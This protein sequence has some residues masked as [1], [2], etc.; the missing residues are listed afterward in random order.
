MSSNLILNS[1]YIYIV[2]SFYSLF[3][4]I[5]S[6]LTLQKYFPSLYSP[7][8]WVTMSLLLMF[9]VL[10]L[11][12]HFPES[13][14]HF[15][16]FVA[17]KCFHSQFSCSEF[18]LEEQFLISIF[19]SQIIVFS[20][21]SLFLSLI[22]IANLLPRSLTLRIASWKWKYLQVAFPFSIL[23][24]TFQFSILHSQLIIISNRTCRILAWEWKFENRKNRHSQFAILN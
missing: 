24:E 13:G 15:L 10:M 3:S 2:F 16:I 14:I 4:V 22:S 6:F 12:L 23:W 9:S 18:A 11:L 5:N 21:H 7:F 1:D 19:Y 17:L 20:L 8:S